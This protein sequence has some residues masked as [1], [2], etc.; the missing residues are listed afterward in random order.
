MGRAVKKDQNQGYWALYEELEVRYG[1][2]MAQ[3]IVDQIQ[4]VEDK[5][6]QPDYMPVKAASEVLELFRA[7]T[8]DSLTQL[9][10]SKAAQ[11]DLAAD[12]INLD[13][14]RLQKNFERNLNCYWQIQHSFYEMYDRALE[15]CK[16]PQ[17]SRLGIG[18]KT[19]DTKIA[20]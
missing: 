12:V 11:E 16:R 7:E 1:A 10:A 9:K 14:Q 5:A 20:G 17:G 6:Y 15:A 3:Q 19:A 18:A 2:P 8:K 4:K 13:A